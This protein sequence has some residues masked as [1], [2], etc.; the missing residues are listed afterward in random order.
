MNS[1]SADVAVARSSRSPLLSH[2][3]SIPP[4]A[5]ARFGLPR[6]ARVRKRG[7]FVAIQRE[8]RK[9]SGP[10]IL[11]FTRVQRIPGPARLGVTVSK[12]VGGAVVRNRV[13]RL[14][15]EVYRL[16]PG[17][18]GGGHDYVFVARPEAA[19]LGLAEIRAEIEALLKRRAS[20]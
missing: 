13:K 15:R 12:R 7:A 11:L 8:G 16:N 1:G 2:P 14:L 20:R 17:W 4:G 6:A 3:P 10:K 5:A 19:T 9:T 18:F